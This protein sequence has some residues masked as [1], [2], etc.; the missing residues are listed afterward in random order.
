M[1]KHLYVL[2][3]AAIA[4]NACGPVYVV[5]Q[6]PPPAPAPP[7]PPPQESEPEVSY[8]SF[9]DQLSPY[10]QWIDDPN[11]GY[12]WLPDAGPDFK[13]Y[14]T[15]G[16]WVYTEDGWTWAS[17]YPWG[18]AAFHYGRWFFQDGY[19]WMWMPGTEWAPAWV[20]WRS[21][22]DYYGW[23]PLEPEISVDASYGG[24]YN[25]PPQYWCFVPHQY[26]GSPQIRNYYVNETRN[27]TIVNN[28]T[29]IHNTTIVNNQ[30]GG[31][32]RNV[33]YGRGPDPQEVGRYSGA[34]V[35]PVVIRQSNAPGEQMSNGTLAIYRPRI[36]SAPQGNRGN[37]NAPRVAPSRVQTLN[38]VR[39]VNT[40]VYNRP[41]GRG[42]DNRGNEYN[43]GN[44]P[45]NRNP[46][47]GYSNQQ[48]SNQQP[49]N[50][51]GGN[52]SA[53]QPGYQNQPAVQPGSNVPGRPY[54]QPSSVPVNQNP[55]ASQPGNGRPSDRPVVQPVNQQPV[56]RPPA[57]QPAT[58][59]GYQN[60]P[61]VQPGGNVPGRPYN[62]PSSVPVNQN[63]ATSQPGNGRS[64]DR[65]V[66]QPGNQ[67]PTNQPGNGRPFERPVAQPNNQ[68][69]NNRTPANQPAAQPAGSVPLPGRPYNQPSSVPVSQNPAG[70]PVNQPAVQP[71]NRPVIQPATAR[72]APVPS[73]V[74]PAPRQVPPPPPPKK[75]VDR[76]D[77][78]Q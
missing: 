24:G 66:T 7:P 73:T 44:T 20:T 46:N 10:G 49:V 74:K 68:Q 63:P 12:V 59:P 77:N 6:D 34:A 2:A 36:N 26:V 31:R 35:R 72:P 65:P 13:P 17:N 39:P 9:Y 1:K 16:H 64:F 29:I 4:L 75:D 56:N 54:N 71:V 19:G 47:S 61:A 69:P 43:N 62:Q 48:Q 57:N 76:R 27:V 58:Q 78:K 55:A 52:Q 67:Q 21:S 23:A 25:P 51:P 28:T 30:G 41:N 45:S 40:A 42:N 53:T 3:I 8:Q 33:N 37:G 11:Y 18:W 14:A 60:Q 22:Q 38:N 32:P 5:H 15:N 70:R 50:R